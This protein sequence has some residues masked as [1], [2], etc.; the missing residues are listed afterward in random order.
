MVSDPTVYVF[1]NATVLVGVTGAAGA[2]GFG[3][4]VKVDV[5]VE[6]LAWVVP[7]D[8]TTYPVVAA[9]RA[10]VS[11]TTQ[12]EPAGTF[13]KEREAPLASVKVAGVTAIGTGVAVPLV[14]VQLTL[15]E[16]EA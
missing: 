3:T 15:N 6:P 13:E 1:V 12:T 16:G 14:N 8:V 2:I 4:T 7:F 10:F 5:T 11:L 9:P